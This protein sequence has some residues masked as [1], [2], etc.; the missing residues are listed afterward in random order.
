MNRRQ[1]REVGW[2]VGR[3]QTNLV[4]ILLL[5]KYLNIGPCLSTYYP[6]HPLLTSQPDTAVVL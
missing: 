3:L 1:P 6:V 4:D 5:V 2:S